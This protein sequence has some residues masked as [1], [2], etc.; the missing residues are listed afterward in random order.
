M[1]RPLPLPSRGGDAPSS[2]QPGPLSR[3][4]R[5]DW[6]DGRAGVCTFWMTQTGK[7]QPWSMDLARFTSPV[8]LVRQR[9]GAPSRPGVYV[10]ACGG[11]VAHVGTSGKLQSRIRS[12]AALGNHR[13]S[14]EVLCAAYCTGA[15][16]TVQWCETTSAADARVLERTLKAVGEPPQPRD[17][18]AGCVNGITLRNDLTAAAGRSTWEAGYIEALFDVGEQ[19]YRLFDGR[20][21]D[22]WAAVGRP[23][24]PWAT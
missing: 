18:F 8:P 19:L 11:C 1:Y 20:F 17:D 13:G 23:R 15:R 3:R 7:W 9:L 2:N 24:G 10:V 22:V 21:D 5:S 14:A 6:H 12:L 16:P 4:G